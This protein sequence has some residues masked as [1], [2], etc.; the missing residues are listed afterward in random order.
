MTPQE[1]AVIDALEVLRK[2]ADDCATCLYAYLSIHAVADRSQAVRSR[3]NRDALFWNVSLHALQASAILAIGRAYETNSTHNVGAFMRVI[4]RNRPVFSRAALRARKQQEV[5]AGD[6]TGL[7]TYMHGIRVPTRSD[8]ARVSRVVSKH[9]AT[10][11]Q[12]YRPLRDQIFAHTL[13]ASAAAIGALFSQTNV[14]ELQ[15]MATYLGLLHDGFWEA[16]HN[17]GRLHLR[18]RRIA[19]NRILDRP[20]GRRTVNP[21]HEDIVVTT[22]RAL[23]P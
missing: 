5:F 10:Y 3:L 11:I 1:Q 4:W 17:G 14:R 21:I 9:R 12:K 19:I 2:Q 16:F 7:N 22:Q 23:Q 13:T 6:L 8:L 15:R 18:R 20:P